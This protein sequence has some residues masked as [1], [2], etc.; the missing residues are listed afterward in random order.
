MHK[1]N[2]MQKQSNPYWIVVGNLIKASD[3][4]FKHVELV[5]HKMT[6]CFSLLDWICI[7]LK[8]ILCVCVCV[9]VCLC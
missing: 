7:K 4:A 5:V 1:S 8:S 9:C 2:M 6:M 3:T